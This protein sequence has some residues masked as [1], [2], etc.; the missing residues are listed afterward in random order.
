MDAS[1]HEP[2]INTQQYKEK[3]A[4][5]STTIND[6]RFRAVLIL[7]CKYE[8]GVYMRKGTNYN[9]QVRKHFNQILNINIYSL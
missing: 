6:E 9:G 5:S 2:V 3:Q 1:L 7:T 8:S 4:K